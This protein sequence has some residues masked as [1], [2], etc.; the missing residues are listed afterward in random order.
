MDSSDWLYDLFIEEAAPALER[1][2]GGRDDNELVFY[3]TN[4]DISSFE[5]DTTYADYDY[6]ASIGLK[7]VSSNYIPYIMF[8]DADVESGIFSRN[9]NSYDGGV[10]IYSKE[11]PSNAII[12]PEIICIKE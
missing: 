4:V 5:N 7:G 12:I 1:H 9:T 10:Y 6:R 3:N 8:D 2:T 11:I